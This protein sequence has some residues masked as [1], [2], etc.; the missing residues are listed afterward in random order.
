VSPERYRLN[1]RAAAL[2]LGGSG[3]AAGSSTYT[4]LRLYGRAPVAT[5]SGVPSRPFIYAS[6]FP[7]R[8]PALNNNIVS[9][10][11]GSR[12]IADFKAA[13]LASYRRGIEPSNCWMAGPLSPVLLRPPGKLVRWWISP[14]IGSAASRRSMSSPAAFCARESS[15]S[16]RVMIH[17]VTLGIARSGE[18]LRSSEPRLSAPKLWGRT[19]LAANHQNRTAGS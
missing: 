8:F 19:R 2:S 4:G 14:P 5:W 3:P 1:M 11:L 18:R 16:G 7:R 17:L 15:G 9:N 12:F 10:S 6:A 13:R